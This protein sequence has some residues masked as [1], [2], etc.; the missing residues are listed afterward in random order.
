MNIITINMKFIAKKVKKI[1]H[2]AVVKSIKIVV[3]E[4]N[5]TCKA[6]KSR[7]FYNAEID[8]SF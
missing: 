6:L 1:S 4:I 5:K 3:V 7:A 8:Y 2:V